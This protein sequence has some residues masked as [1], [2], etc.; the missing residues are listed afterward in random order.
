ME[1]KKYQISQKIA[2]VSKHAT[3]KNNAQL[4]APTLQAT[5]LTA[6][7]CNLNRSAALH[8]AAF[9]QYRTPLR[10]KARHGTTRH[11]TAGQLQLCPI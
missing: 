4:A 10:A 7:C 3:K 6:T 2:T 5:T 11:D 8:T 1:D 9:V